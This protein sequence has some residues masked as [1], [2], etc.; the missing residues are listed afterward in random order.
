MFLYSIRTRY[1]LC[2]LSSFVSD[3][4]FIVRLG[5]QVILRCDRSGKYGCITWSLFFR[6]LLNSASSAL[7]NSSVIAGVSWLQYPSLR[8]RRKN[9]SSLARSAAMCTRTR[10]C[11]PFWTVR[12][13][14]DICLCSRMIL[15]YM[16]SAVVQLLLLDQLISWRFMSLTSL[17]VHLCNDKRLVVWFLWTYC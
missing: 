4:F 3:M 5:S 6:I 9:A 11:T 13:K 10:D 2:D 17:G 8:H 12:R 16:Y 1:S 7:S 15:M 14:F